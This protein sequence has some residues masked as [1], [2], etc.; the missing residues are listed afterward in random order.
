[1][2]GAKRATRLRHAQEAS[3]SRGS[4]LPK[5]H[6]R[7]SHVR[8]QAPKPACAPAAAADRVPCCATH[9]L[10][11]HPLLLASQRV[12]G[13]HVPAVKPQERVP[14]LLPQ[15]QRGLALQ[16]LRQLRGQGAPRP[17]GLGRRCGMRRRRGGPDRAVGQGPER[18]LPAVKVYILMRPKARGCPPPTAASRARAQIEAALLAILRS[19]DGEI[20]C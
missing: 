18:R 19:N 13:P 2:G 8:V 15:A 1:V 17:L 10:H 5:P 9:Q 16:R 12:L 20:A 4:Q 6:Q 11:A 3:G 14:E 7:L